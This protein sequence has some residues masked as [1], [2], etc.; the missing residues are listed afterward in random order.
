[1]ETPQVVLRQI[2]WVP[3]DM[4]AEPFAKAELLS[5]EAMSFNPNN[6]QMLR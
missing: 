4:F 1:M 2:F 5:G 3:L 6:P